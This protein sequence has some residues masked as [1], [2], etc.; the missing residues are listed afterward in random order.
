MSEL[1]ANALKRDEPILIDGGLATQ[2]ETQG[3]DLNNSLWSAALLRSDPEAIV[4]AHRAYLE[5][6]AECIATASYQASRGG[7]MS[8][9]LSENDADDLIVRSVDLAKQA[10]TEFRRDTVGEREPWVAASIGPFGAALHDGSEY[11]GDYCA[12]S[13]ELLEFHKQRLGLLDDQN[14]DVLACETIP[15]L[16]E[17]K[18]LCELLRDC[19]NPAWISFSCRDGGHVSDGTP[20]GQVAQLFGDHPRVLAVGVN[21]TA[22]SLML[23]LIAE[24]QSAV[25]DKAIIVY[26]NSGEIY[27]ATDNSWSGTTTAHECGAAAATWV[28]AGAKIVG[29]CCRMGPE[30]IREIRRQLATS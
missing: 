7:F 25:P 5:S 29:G 10:I 15:S 11:T 3:Y 21:C 27:D 18:V 12:T 20:I 23:P 26:P 1:F 14:P 8:L 17:A 19:R 24:L 16:A 4:A 30:H 6:G 13:D 22:P 28:A 2:C 9:G